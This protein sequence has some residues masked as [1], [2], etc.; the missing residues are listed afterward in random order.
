VLDE[1]LEER[2]AAI[3]RPLRARWPH[4][5]EEAIMASNRKQAVV[6]EGATIL[7]PVGTAPGLVVAPLETG[8]DRLWLY[9][10]GR[11]ASSGRFGRPRSR[12]RRS[13]PLSRAHGV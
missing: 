11:Q 9:F 12:P 5:S 3:L 6:P 7:E 10:Q 13:R 2:I 1:A 8:R 4:L